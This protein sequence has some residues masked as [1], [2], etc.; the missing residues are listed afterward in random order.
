MSQEVN[1]P[2]HNWKQ[3]SLAAKLMIIITIIT[4]LAIYATDSTLSSDV[5]KYGLLGIVYASTITC[6]VVSIIRHHKLTI[7]VLP[8]IIYVCITYFDGAA[9]KFN[10]LLLL[11]LCLF[12]LLPRQ[13]KRDVYNI[14]RK[15]LVVTSGLGLFIYLCIMVGIPFPHRVLAYYGTHSYGATYLDF[16]I[17]YAVVN[18]FCGLF[19]EPGYLGTVIALILCIE[20]MNLNRKG[21]IVLILCG[22]ATFSM[23]F[24]TIVFLY[25]VLLI[26]KRPS[27]LVVLLALYVFIFYI[28]P[29]LSLGDDFN[30]LMARFTFTDGTFAGDNRSNDVVDSHFDRLL[31]SSYVTWGYGR[32][33]TSSLDTMAGTYKSYILDYGI[34]GFILSFGSL[35]LSALLYCKKNLYSLFFVLCFFISVYQ[36]PNIFSLPYFVLL[37]G[38]LEE[39]RSRIVKKL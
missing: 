22:I 35:L 6:V 12:V 16:Y 18:R 3:S 2:S 28:V 29:H 23:A 4:G 36:R 13:D 10:V 21:N 5:V 8:A 30:H 1:A 14:Y 37:Y 19:N 7:H 27:V 15:F 20:R 24:Y 39:I 38:G 34:A 17:G 33:Y 32:G 25:I 31:N 11:V 9:E 26:W